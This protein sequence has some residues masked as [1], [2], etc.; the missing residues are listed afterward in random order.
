MHG[1]T[2]TNLLKCMGNFLWMYD[3]NVAWMHCQF[4]DLILMHYRMQTLMYCPMPM[5]HQSISMN[6]CQMRM[7]HQLYFKINVNA[8]S[9]W[10]HGLWLLLWSLSSLVKASVGCPPLGALGS[11]KFHCM[12]LCNDNHGLYSNRSPSKYYF[13]RIVW[14]FSNPQLGY[15][16]S[17]RGQSTDTLINNDHRNK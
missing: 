5:H 3:Q 13:N 14:Y 11:P 17:K 6:A 9:V 1:Q 2:Q 15:I 4:Q 12:L 7:H 8:L 16:P 10:L